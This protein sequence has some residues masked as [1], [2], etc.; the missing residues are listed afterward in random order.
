MLGSVMGNMRNIALSTTVTLL[1]EE[2][3]RDKA[4]GMI[5]T[6]NGISFAI[7]SVASGMII[8]FL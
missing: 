1:F 5:G 7:T 2:D 3:K 6:V 4:N 8:G